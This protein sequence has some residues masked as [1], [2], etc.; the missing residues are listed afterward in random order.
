V[1][2]I[3]AAF[4]PG[5]EAPARAGTVNTFT[6]R[7]FDAYGNAATNY[8]GTVHFTST[9]GQAIVP[10]DYTFTA[11][12]AD[13]HV[14]AAVLGTA[15]SQT[16][17]VADSLLGDRTGSQTVTVLPAAASRLLVQGYPSPTEAG[18]VDTFSVTALDA[19]GNVVTDYQGTVHFTSTDAQAILPSDYTFTAADNGTHIF[20]AVLSTAGVQS[21]TASQA[22][23][24]LTG[25]ENGILVVPAAASTFVVNTSASTVTAGGSTSVTVTAYDAYGNV[26]TGYSGTVHLTSSYDQA[27]LPTDY[28][29]TAAD[30]GT[31]TFRVTFHRL[32]QQSLTVSD[33]LDATIFGTI[34]VLVQKPGQDGRGQ[35]GQ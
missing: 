5:G 20:G 4:F 35:N 8:V 2:T 17:T 23:G 14:F 32:G 28:P 9:D 12:A 27:T 26:A 10:H 1:G 29:F 16:L 22:D 34:D 30:G 7:A 3:G 11:A 15:G 19:Y 25:S 13:S 21:L 31:H 24:S 33:T 6:V 18:S